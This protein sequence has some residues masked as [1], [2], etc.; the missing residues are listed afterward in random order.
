MAKAYRTCGTGP[1]KVPRCAAARPISSAWRDAGSGRRDRKLAAEQVGPGELVRDAVEGAGAFCAGVDA[2]AR[3]D[4]VFAMD[5]L[6]G[7]L[8]AGKARRDGR[9]VLEL[10]SAVAKEG[11]RAFGVAAKKILRAG[12]VKNQRGTGGQP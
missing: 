12:A 3:Q 9:A 10:V 2:A 11:T 1:R 7:A 4:G 5:R 6:A 8:R